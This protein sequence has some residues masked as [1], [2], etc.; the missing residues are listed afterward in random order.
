MPEH[1][2]H[3]AVNSPASRA[4]GRPKSFH[5]KTESIIIAALDR[6]LDI[7]KVV[8]AG[9]GMSL[10]EIAEAG[11]QS[12]ATV[13]RILITLRK[14]AMVDFEET[15]QLWHVGTGA[16]RIGSS[17]LRRTRLLE[18]SRLVM[19]RLMIETGETANLAIIDHGE[20]IFIS[21]VETHEPIRA[22]F[23]PG[24]RGP[25]HASGIGKAIL[26]YQSLEQFTLIAGQGRFEA[27]TRKTIT[28]EAALAQELKKIKKLGWAVDDEERTPGM[29]CIAAPIFNPF[30]EAVA[31]ISISGPSVRM[32]PQ[33]DA[34][35]GKIIRRAA[36][37]ITL[38]TG[39]RI[40]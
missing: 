11:D 4:R 8:A 9:S 22:F 13:Y 40:P 36:D 6:A 34:G 26:A 35:L 19:E 37:E 15:N 10:T 39:G 28:K 20:V 2:E 23:R 12:P 7:L 27:F 5:D 25:V 31:G 18:Q 29:R 17:F 32:P 38:S 14:H 21:Q 24:T 33:R 16:F 1:K 30:G 3:K